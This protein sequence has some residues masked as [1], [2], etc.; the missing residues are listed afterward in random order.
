MTVE[1]IT[2]FRAGA[3][4]T[5][6]DWLQRALSRESGRRVERHEFRADL[7]PLRSPRAIAPWPLP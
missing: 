1:A 3:F 2:L 6:L 4:T 5:A 7:T